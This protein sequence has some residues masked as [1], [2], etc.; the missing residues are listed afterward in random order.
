MFELFSIV[1]FNAQ[2]REQMCLETH[3]QYEFSFLGRFGQSGLQ[4]KK[5]PNCHKYAFFEASFIMFS[6]AKNILK[7]SLD[8]IPSP[9]SSVKIQIKAGK[10]A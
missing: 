8:L 1:E 10:F 3:F 5:N 9:S 6:W 4:R 2:I 7:G